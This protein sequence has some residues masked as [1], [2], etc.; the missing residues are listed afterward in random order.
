MDEKHRK[1]APSEVI[2]LINWLMTFSSEGSVV[3]LPFRPM[4]PDTDFQ[5]EGRIFRAG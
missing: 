1:N 4:C 5:I 3:S 2:R